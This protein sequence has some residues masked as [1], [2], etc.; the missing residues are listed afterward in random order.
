MRRSSLPW[1]MGKL[2]WAPPDATF[3]PIVRTVIV[4]DHLFIRDILKKICSAELNFDVVAE[5]S[6]GKQ[7]VGE[8]LRTQ[9]DLVLLDLEL[10]GTDGFTVIELVRRAGLTPRILVISSFLDDYTVYRI[11]KA[12]VHGF[13]DKNLNNVA[14]VAA[15]I[16]AVS[17]GEARFS[18][19]F[20]RSKAARHADPNSFDKVLSEREIAVLSMIGDSLGDQEIGERLNISDRTAEKHRFNI[21]KRLGLKSTRALVRYAQEHGFTHSVARPTPDSAH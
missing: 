6:D 2:H 1:R 8:I 14:S 12:M 15:A 16:R 13:L 11:E 5:A 18:E 4:E 20:Q 3:S 7:A 10:I 9:P 21:Q 17:R 19:A